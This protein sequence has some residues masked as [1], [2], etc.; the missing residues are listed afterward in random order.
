MK[1]IMNIMIKG[2]YCEK[3]NKFKKLIWVNLN[4]IIKI[5]SDLGKKISKIN[6]YNNIYI[7]FLIIGN[8]YGHYV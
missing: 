7:Y 5:Y 3:I 6:I 4:F 8:W 2:V 1:N